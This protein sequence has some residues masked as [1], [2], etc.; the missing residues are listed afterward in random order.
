MDEDKDGYITF[1]EL[2]KILIE[3]EINMDFDMLFDLLEEVNPEK[4][5]KYDFN[6]IIHFFQISP[7]DEEYIVCFSK[8]S[9]HKSIH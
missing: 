2:R 6:M 7:E 5:E 8:T 3:A 4:K 1:D 9:I